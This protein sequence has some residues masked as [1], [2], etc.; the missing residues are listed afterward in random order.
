M[1][2]RNGFVSNSSSSSFIVI[3][4]DGCDD[5]RL[6][7]VIDNNTLVVDL[8]LGNSEFGWDK[9]TYFDVGSKLIFSYLQ[10]QYAGKYLDMLE[11]VVKDFCGCKHIKWNISDNYESGGWGY[12]DHQS[13]A[14]EGQNMEMFENEQ[15]LRNFLFDNNS[16]IETGNDNDE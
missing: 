2:I 6:N 7:K 14:V 8:S 11:S 16:Y 5:L 1:K 15:V 4:S 13:S 9:D 10:T 12:I 3:S